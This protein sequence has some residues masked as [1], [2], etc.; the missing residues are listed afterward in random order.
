MFLEGS[1]HALANVSSVKIQTI[2]KIFHF[3]LLK[4]REKLVDLAKFSKLRKQFYKVG[5]LL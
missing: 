5:N 1:V 2:H 3:R 4:E